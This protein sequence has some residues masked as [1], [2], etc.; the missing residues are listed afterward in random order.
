MPGVVGG[1]TT[2]F[3]VSDLNYQVPEEFGMLQHS[4]CDGLTS[5]AL[6][7]F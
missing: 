2:E 6:A 7:F 4:V 5:L 1:I 3:V